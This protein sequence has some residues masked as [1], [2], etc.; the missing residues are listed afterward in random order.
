M[1]SIKMLRKQNK[2]SQNEAASILGISRR[3]YQK[4]ESIEADNDKLDYL[5]HVLGE[6]T[7]VDEENGLLTIYEIQNTVNDVL[8]NYDVRSC[9][10]FGSYAKGKAKPISDVDLLID[11]DITGLDYYG[12]IEELREKLHKKVDLLLLR[13]IQENAQMLCE[14][15]KDGIKIYG[16]Y[17]RR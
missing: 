6:K 15:L 14:I 2:L 7:K 13:S 12:L 5:M 8:K 4:Y 17:Q 16:Q 3:T 11:S 10:L 9:Y 1:N